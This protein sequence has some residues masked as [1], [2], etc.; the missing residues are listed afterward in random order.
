MKNLRTYGN[1]PFG[2]VVVHGGPGASGEMAPVANELSRCGGV[3]EPLQ[4]ATSVRGQVQELRS[5]LREHAELPA[6][7]IG[8]SWGAW[9]V[10]ILASKHH[11]LVKKLIL[12]GSGPFEEKYAADIMKTRLDRLAKKDRLEIDVLAERLNDPAIEDKNLIMG[13][14]ANLL[15]EAD[16]YDSLSVDNAPL[17]CQYDIYEKVWQEA[18]EL[19]RSGELL[20]LGERIGCQVTAIHGDYDPHPFEG[21]RSPLSRIIKDFRFILLENCGHRPWL[22]KGARDK[23]YKILETELGCGS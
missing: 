17:D 22:E 18:S 4:T 7:L 10:F 20:R 11:S 1:V 14:L 15:A 23:F 16:S 19:R 8:H 2:V 12:V 13:K 5:I 21:V 3:L 6:T 9:L